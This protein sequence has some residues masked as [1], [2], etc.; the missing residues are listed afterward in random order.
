MLFRESTHAQKY[1][2]G[3]CIH[4]FRDEINDHAPQP[5]NEERQHR[6]PIADEALQ[7]WTTVR[8]PD[9][10][11]KSTTGLIRRRVHRAR[12]SL[13]SL[14]LGSCRRRNVS[15]GRESAARPKHAEKRNVQQMKKKKI[16]PLLQHTAYRRASPRINSPAVRPGRVV[17]GGAKM[18]CCAPSC[19]L[20]MNFSMPDRH[21]TPKPKMLSVK[22][23]RNTTIP[24][25]SDLWVGVPSFDAVL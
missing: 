23:E 1:T 17:Q 15:D 9:P 16:I 14:P 11:G 5:Q 7:A 24:L 21:A 2:P 6:P 8:T 4:S 10:R 13:L 19:I 22:K 20:R 18:Y 12:R 3:L 25:S